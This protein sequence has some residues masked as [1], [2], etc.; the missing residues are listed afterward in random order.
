M[1]V[2]NPII[3]CVQHNEISTSTMSQV[4]PSTNS[5]N[6]I[7]AMNDK[8]SDSYEY[9]DDEQSEEDKRDYTP[10]MIDVK[11]AYDSQFKAFANNFPK[12]ENKRIHIT[13]VKPRM[14]VEMGS[15]KSSVCQAR[16]DIENASTE[17]IRKHIL[18]KLGM[19]HEPNMTSYPKLTEEYREILCKRVN[20]DP[21]KCLGNK[22]SSLEYQSDDPIDSYYDDG[23]DRD[24]VTEEEDVQFLSYENR[25]YAFPSSKF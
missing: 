1:I 10:S 25:I 4:T 22:P 16:K 21:E 5:I 3:L 14:I 2:F 17:S 8:S 20:I 18:M 9:E 12:N 24:V 13:T 6:I 15:C 7:P 19:T 23:R 11:N